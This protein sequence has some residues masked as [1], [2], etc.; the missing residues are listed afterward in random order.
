M[1]PAVEGVTIERL[2]GPDAEAVVEPLLREY[3]P[4]AAAQLIDHGLKVDDVDEM[5]E[6]HHEAFRVEIPKLVGPRGRLLVAR[7]GEHAGGPVLGMGALKP[8]DAV[9]AEIKRMYVRP[10]GRSRGIGRTVLE[11]LVEGARAEGY[12]TARLE[13]AHFMTAALRL[14]RSLGFRDIPVFDG[15]ESAVSGFESLARY[16]RL[17]LWPRT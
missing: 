1:T 10:A 3:V 8:V 16:L 9:T 13:T 6:Q 15:S 7:L 5:I 2:T 17:D 11:R 14:Y 12:A 4:W